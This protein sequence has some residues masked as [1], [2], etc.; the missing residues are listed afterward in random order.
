[1]PTNGRNMADTDGRGVVITRT[2]HTHNVRAYHSECVAV[3]LTI[4][5]S[6]WGAQMSSCCSSSSSEPASRPFVCHDQPEHA[7]CVW[8][9]FWI[10]NN[11]LEFIKNSPSC[12][13]N[14]SVYSFAYA[15]ARRLFKASWKYASL[16]CGRP[17]N[18]KLPMYSRQSCSKLFTFLLRVVSGRE[19]AWA[20]YATI[21]WPPH[22]PKAKISIFPRK[23]EL[24]CRRFFASCLQH[25]VAYAQAPLH[26]HIER[27]GRG[28]IPIPFRMHS[29]SKFAV[30]RQPVN[31][32]WNV[33]AAATYEAV[34]QNKGMCRLQI[35]L[36]I[37]MRVRIRN[38]NKST[39]TAEAQGIFGA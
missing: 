13:L 31:D 10:F 34:R 1:M 35:D 32:S 27:V 29:A 38:M 21:L 11:D 33:W 20:W 6:P 12:W 14:Y 15:Y 18:M 28:V 23:I 26:L 7:L 19:E 25:F 16:L 24:C 8:P 17:Q 3:P 22:M 4:C 2:C 36:C 9:T 37:R 39:V 30:L 5:Q